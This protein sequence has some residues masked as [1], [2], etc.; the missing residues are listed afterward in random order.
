MA[1]TRLLLLTPRDCDL[2]RTLSLCVRMLSLRQIG[3]T[4]WARSHSPE[5][6]ALE[7]LNRLI[8]AGWLWRCRTIALR[9]S[10]LTAAQVTWRS[11]RM[12][13][14]FGPAA[15]RLRQRWSSPTDPVTIFLATSRTARRFGGRRRDWI[16]RPFQISH[17]LGVAE[18][19]LAIRRLRPQRVPLW[20][21]EDRLA[22]F[23]RRQKLPDAVLASS[24]SAA[25]QLVLEFG[26]GYSKSRLRAF[27]ADNER[28]GLPYEIW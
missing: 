2:L 3:R 24:P 12:A 8:R 20:I 23:R 1:G 15:W 7:R 26:A 22:P 16:S 10:P 5:E 13:P 21:D 27:H 19:F 25:V 14:E 4:W 28:R 6:A 18:M 17:D 9:L 11:G